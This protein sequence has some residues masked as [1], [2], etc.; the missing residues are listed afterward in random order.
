[1]AKQW[2]FLPVP[3]LTAQWRHLAM[4]NYRVDPQLLRPLVPRATQ[5]DLYDGGA[6]IS[7]VGF[8][9]L[10]TA[11]LGVPIPLHRNFEE[12]N[13]R[14]YVRRE[15]GDEIRRGVV[16]IKEI[17]PRRAIAAVAR[18]VYNE[19]YIAVPM[20]HDFT[21]D[22]RG[23]CAD[24]PV[25]Y[26]F[27]TAERWNHLRLRPRGRFACP[28]SG[29]LDEFITEHYW[30]YCSQRDGGT[31][32][33]RVEHPQ[34]QLRA[35]EDAEFDCDVAKVYGE[36]FVEPLSAPPHSALLADGSDVAVHRPARIK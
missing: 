9:F 21:L 3:F 36:A 2:P 33:Y 11:V 12:L 31:V 30:G 22:D 28:R 35:A 4:L 20:R 16:F 25:E 19:N 34:W 6:Y 23:R 18:R 17:V 14:F 10:R 13:L 24:A 29:S 27:K 5:L 32:E 26:G 15:V 1:M 8:M 7:L